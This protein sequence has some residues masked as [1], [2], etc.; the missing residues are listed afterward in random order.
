[1][2][3]ILQ[4]D[5]LLMRTWT[6]VDV[7]AL[8]EICRD[9]EIMLHIGTGKPYQSV[10]EAINF[11]N[12]TVA[13]QAENGFCRWAI[14]EKASQRIIGSCGFARLENSGEIELGYLLARQ[15]WGKGFA[16]EAAAACL[17]YGFKE[18]G[19]SSVVALTDPE[20]IASQRVVEKLGFIWRGIENYGGESNSVY[21]AVN[22][23]E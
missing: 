4:T 19:F 17:K 18:L 20:H 11:L 2:K 12:W 8:F 15:A 1:M 23:E 6:L 16:T 10:D 5:R 22:P 21:V 3:E 14:V 13:Y 9:P 7:K